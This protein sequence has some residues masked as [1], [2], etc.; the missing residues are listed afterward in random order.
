[1]IAPRE[2]FQTRH[3]DTDYGSTG[4]ARQLS[5]RF[6]WVLMC[7]E[8]DVFQRR[9]LTRIRTQEFVRQWIWFKQKLEGFPCDEASHENH[10]DR[11]RRQNYEEL[12]LRPLAADKLFSLEYLDYSSA[13]V[14]DR[15]E[16]LDES[17]WAPDSVDVV[18]VKLPKHFTVSKQR[19]DWIALFDK[20]TK[21][22]Q[23]AKKQA[24]VSPHKGLFE[25]AL[26][27]LMNG[28]EPGVDGW[29]DARDFLMRYAPE[30]ASRLKSVAVVEACCATVERWLQ[31]RIAASSSL[32]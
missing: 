10:V 30:R 9:F 26:Y 17:Y 18:L 27:R 25:L 22:R 1:M 29:H 20:I 13:T 2:K 23:R 32:A 14:G 5:A 11:L 4:S 15:E 3:T 8:K 24:P 12:V 7:D 16:F 31:A 28:G 6:C 21:S 19:D